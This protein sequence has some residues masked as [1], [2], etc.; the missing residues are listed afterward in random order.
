M[1]YFLDTSALVKV[2]HRELGT[3]RVLS[4]YKGQSEIALSELSKVEFISAI[5]RKYREKEIN[6]T[7][8]NL[9]IEKFREDMEVGGRYEVLE[10]SPVIIDEAF[11]LVLKYGRTSSLRTLDSIQ[12]AFFELYCDEGTI[13][14]CSDAKL[15]EIAKHENYSVLVP[16]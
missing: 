4:I 2:Y 12:L 1:T 9:L 11:Q 15:V 6:R 10:F 3:E 16:G 5:H 14:V 7:T 13:F 8:L